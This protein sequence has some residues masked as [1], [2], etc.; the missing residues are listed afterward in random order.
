MR[1]HDLMSKI[2]KAR[3][4]DRYVLRLTGIFDKITRMF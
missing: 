3:V 1:E 4:Y 2:M